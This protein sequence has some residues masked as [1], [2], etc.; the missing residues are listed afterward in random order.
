[1]RDSLQP[2]KK[3]IGL[4]AEIGSFFL[5]RGWPGPDLDRL[6]RAARKTEHPRGALLF[7][8]NQRCSSFQLLLSGRIRIFRSDESGKETTLQ[9]I[10]PGG[11]VGCA[12]LFLGASYPAS[13]TAEEDSVILSIPGPEFL[14]L[15]ERRP[16]LNRRF[17][18][19]L[20]SRL[21]ALADALQSREQETAPERVASYLRSRSEP[22]T[23]HFRLPGTKRALA[24]ELGMA[25]ETFSRALAKLTRGG[26]V[27]V[28][29]RIIEIFPHRNR[30]PETKNP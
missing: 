16:D 11:L 8:Q 29:G 19:A 15:L 14:D 13:A 26:Q 4:L 3:G 2:T 23:G 24:E 5:F 7:H 30:S 20:A 6:A 25:P 10:G 17:I 1:M 12:A 18:A 22:G 21:N 27:R 9:V 28:R